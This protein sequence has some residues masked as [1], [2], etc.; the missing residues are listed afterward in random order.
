MLYGEEPDE[1]E[2]TR[3]RE[4]YDHLCRKLQ[5][6]PLGLFKR[7]LGANNLDLRYNPLGDEA[8]RALSIAIEVGDVTLPAHT[9]TQFRQPR[10]VMTDAYNV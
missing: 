9:H 4:V 7:Q 8:V 1:A 2:V 10:L 3:V 5:L 6:L